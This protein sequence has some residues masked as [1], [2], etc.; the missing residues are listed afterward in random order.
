MTGYHS[1]VAAVAAICLTVAAGCS[2]NENS[3]SGSAESGQ[4]PTAIS[5]AN[6]ANNAFA[7][8]NGSLSGDFS[9]P[10]GAARYASVCIRLAN[11][12]Q[13]LA[14]SVMGDKPSVGTTYPVTNAQTGNTATVEYAEGNHGTK[15]WAATS[16][17]VRIE[18]VARNSIGLGFAHVVMAPDTGKNANTAT[19]TLTLSGSQQATDVLGFV[20]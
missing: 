18:S 5:G 17:T 6:G 19:G 2:S 7:K 11:V 4:C 8:F 14:I 10:D 15:V 12:P 16:G 9:G 1:S 13:A 3:G 20:P